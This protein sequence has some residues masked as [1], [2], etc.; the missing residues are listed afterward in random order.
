VFHS[1]WDGYAGTGTNSL[2]GFMFKFKLGEYVKVNH[3]SG[4]EWTGMVYQ[5][6]DTGDGIEY[7]ITNAPRAYDGCSF[8]L[9]AWE[10][11]LTLAHRVSN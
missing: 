4:I 8:P 11:E 6:N 2:G 9:L 10:D 5:R 3:Y 1:L 7:W